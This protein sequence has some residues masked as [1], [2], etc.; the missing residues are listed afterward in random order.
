MRALT[1]VKKKD[2]DT[3]VEERNPLWLKDK[4]RYT[5]SIYSFF[6]LPIPFSNFSVEV[7]FTYSTTHFFF[8]IKYHV[9]ILAH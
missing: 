5:P 9:V 3:K 4:A 8:L 7:M 1:A 2:R 6:C